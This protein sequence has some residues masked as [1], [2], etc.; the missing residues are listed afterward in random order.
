MRSGRT[1]ADVVVQVT[2]STADRLET[3]PPWATLVRAP[4]PGPMTLDGT[5][6]WVLR[7]PGAPDCL[8]VDPGP[9]DEGHLAAV[10]AF[11]PVRGI[12]VTHG[13]HDHTESL[14]RFGEL[15]GAQVIDAAEL[16]G[17]GLKVQRLDTPGHTADS[18]CFLVTGSGGRAVLTGDTILGR[19]STVVAWPDGDLGSYLASLQRLAELGPIPVLPGHGPARSDCSVAAAGYLRHR[20][21]R[22]DQ[23]RAARKAGAETAEEVVAVVYHDVDPA[24][25]FAAQWTVQAQLAY[26]DSRSEDPT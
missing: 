22:L 4:N 14:N 1:I 15:T 24:L 20:Q 10:A 16:T 8:V 25:R 23:V 5:N 7:E 9:L 13:H 11:G 26:L 17:C 12:L 18:V 21:E 2:G 6:T 3:L 19:G